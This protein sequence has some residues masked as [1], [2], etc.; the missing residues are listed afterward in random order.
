MDKEKFEIIKYKIKHGLKE[1]KTKEYTEG[2]II[3]DICYIFATYEA[4]KN[5]FITYGI[6]NPPEGIIDLCIYGV[7]PSGY[8]FASKGLCD[9]IIENKE[10]IIPGYD[11]GNKELEFKFGSKKL[12]KTKKED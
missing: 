12:I 3:N 10:K 8:I 4:Y 2:Y 1:A 9:Y 7:T 6:M 11:Y 5:Y